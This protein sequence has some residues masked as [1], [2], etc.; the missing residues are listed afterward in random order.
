MWPGP[1]HFPDF[2][3]PKAEQYWLDMTNYMRDTLK[4]SPGGYWIDMNELASFIPGERD[5]KNDEDCYGANPPAP[6]IVKEAIDDR[7][8]VPVTVSGTKALADKT[9]TLSTK[10]YS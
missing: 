7:L 3:N 1:V 2:N 4:V 8:Y 5:T 10:H 6:P 9:I